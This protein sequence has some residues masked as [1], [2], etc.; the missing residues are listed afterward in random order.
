MR[1]KTLAGTILIGLLMGGCT[2]LG[3]MTAS[4]PVQNMQL[5]GVGGLTS[6]EQKQINV[7]NGS[8]GNAA[9]RN[10]EKFDEIKAMFAERNAYN[11]KP[12][13]TRLEGK[14][15]GSGGCRKI[16]LNSNSIP[17]NIFLKAAAGKRIVRVSNDDGEIVMDTP[18][19]IQVDNECDEMV[20]DRILGDM[21]IAYTINNDSLNIMPRSTKNYGLALLNIKK[22]Y[23]SSSQVSGVASNSGGS[24]SGGSSSGGSSSGGSSSGGS[25]SGASGGKVTN[26]SIDLDEFDE[27]Q[28]SVESML[29][30]NSKVSM[31][32]TAGLM[33][34]YAKPSEQRKIQSIIE[35]YNSRM[36]DRSIMITAKILE[37]NGNDLNEAGLSMDILLNSVKSAVNIT[38]NFAGA[39]QG[40]N[41]TFRTF[42][43]SGKTLY[44][45]QGILRQNNIRFNQRVAPSVTV[46]N[47]RGAIINMGA[48]EQYVKSIELS[49]S[50][51]GA[52]GSTTLVPS[53]KLAI[54]QTGV[55]LDVMPSKMDNGRIMAQLR[56][57]ITDKTG[58]QQ[59]SFTNIGTFNS[60][61]LA[62]R[63][64]N[65]QVSM[66]DGETIVITGLTRSTESDT[67]DGVPGLVDL[68]VIGALFGHTVK[69]TKKSEAI[70]FLTMKS[71]K[72]MKNNVASSNN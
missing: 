62:T 63:E 18:I 53:P 46:D 69:E 57:S 4:K 44:D 32:K 25:S 16:S 1:N 13:A 38:T 61:I 60:P 22:S 67:V 34:A 54:L 65:T 20:I 59:F 11:R 29:G 6:I 42:N 64:I 40:S 21:D 43:T 17:F 39:I 50:P 66:N 48:Q 10:K 33:I 70:I 12:V 71:L 8:E 55:Q 51:A 27:L 2:S 3:G 56:V 68:P 72:H 31:N 23:S 19:S 52:N 7:T 15:Q 26:K 35:K 37:V 47:R 45:I 58:E 14:S 36:V 41:G 9:A 5:G 28:E 49:A 24:S 30:K